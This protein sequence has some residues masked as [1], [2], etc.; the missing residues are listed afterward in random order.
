MYAIKHIYALINIYK[1]F[2]IASY[3]IER[4]GISIIHKVKKLK[5]KRKMTVE[6]T[7]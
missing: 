2:L 7:V 5:Q 1:F 4:V 3:N 6:K